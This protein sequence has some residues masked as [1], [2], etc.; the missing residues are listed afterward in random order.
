M[1]AGGTVAPLDLDGD[2]LPDALEDVLL[3]RYA[4]VAMLCD[5][6]SSLP[7]SVT[8]VR[9]QLSPNA[10]AARPRA[11]FPVF[12]SF[13]D[14]IRRGLSDPS[15]WTVYGHAYQRA[16][17]GVELQYWYYYPYNDGH[18]LFDHESDWEHVSVEL[19]ADLHPRTLAAAAHH[20]IA[21]GARTPWSRLRF[22]DGHPLVYVA[23][24]THASYARL[25]DAPVWERMPAPGRERPW[26]VG[27]A[28]GEARL[29]NV[30]ER[31]R[32]RPDQDAAFMLSYA[33]PWGAIAPAFGSAAPLGPPFQRGF[34]V[35]TAAAS[36]R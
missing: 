11:A 9:E 20:D 34:C 3:Q 22:A 31:G 32:P 35:D 16:D 4:P 21:P 23:A 26:R 2:G 36:C 33:G 19:D 15:R 14:A 28:P 5:D 18:L 13:D 8:W 10:G 27:S 24:G 25:D 17:R 12:A 30:G 29:V 1:L 7:A 6:E